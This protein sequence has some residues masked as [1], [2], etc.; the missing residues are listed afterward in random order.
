MNAPVGTIQTDSMV[1][2]KAEFRR[3]EFFND[4]M[5]PQGVVGMLGA[6]VEAEQGRLTI[7]S[8]HG[9]AE[10]ESSDQKLYTLLAPHL[11]RAVEINHALAARQIQDGASRLAFE[12]LDRALLVVD[13]S[14]RIL[15]ANARATWLLDCDRL[16]SARG[17]LLGHL[18]PDTERLHGLIRRCIGQRE[19]AGIGA[20]IALRRKS[21]EADVVALV[22]PLKLDLCGLPVR[23]AAVV[24]VSERGVDRAV[25]QPGIQE[26]YGLTPAE[27]AIAVEVMK[28]DGVSAVAKRLGVSS[29][30]ART[31]LSR[32]FAKTGTH[33]QAELVRLLM[34]QTGD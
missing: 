14:A 21:G 24:I 4:F 19:T 29:T 2:P 12:Y 6:A 31:H 8:L 25:S 5:R 33:R 30:T 27:A 26:Q 13:A 22:A 10:F 32:I 11:K 3:S 34:R 17:V 23:P 1:M 7:L 9:H 28:G 16:R 18:A 15:Y 20:E